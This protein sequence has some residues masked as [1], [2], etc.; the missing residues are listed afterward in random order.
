MDAR[1]LAGL[2]V[3]AGAIGAVAGCGTEE[4]AASPPP[5]PPP[6][7]AGTTAPEPET[8]TEP[9]STR[10]DDVD[11]LPAI[12][13]ESPA[14]GETVSSPVVVSGSA[15]VFEANVTVRILGAGGRELA[16]TFT[17]ATCGSGCR[18]DFSVSVPFRVQAAQPGRIV[19]H[20]DDAAGTGRPP[21]V[22]R[23]PVG[24]AP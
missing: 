2:L 1:A 19:V 13:V 17:T 5:P 7:D 8:T 12:V 22:V 21:H 16:E 10:S 3:V 11:E 15:N 20:D 14:A 18:G 24:L 9:A 23:I 6:A 4:R